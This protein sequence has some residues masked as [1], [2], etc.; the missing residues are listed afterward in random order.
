MDHCTSLY[1][2][3]NPSDIVGAPLTTLPPATGDKQ[4]NQHHLG[5]DDQCPV[6]IIQYNT[7]G[8]TVLKKEKEIFVMAR[9]PDC[10]SEITPVRLVL[11]ENLTKFLTICVSCG[12]LKSCQPEDRQQVVMV[13]RE[14]RLPATSADH[15]RRSKQSDYPRKQRAKLVLLLL[16]LLLLLIACFKSHKQRWVISR[17]PGIQHKTCTL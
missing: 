11:M 8:L 13:L 6:S 16:L 5:T 7:K 17:L 1:F 14:L 10:N 4:Q 15:D 12:G 2:F 9:V 3:R